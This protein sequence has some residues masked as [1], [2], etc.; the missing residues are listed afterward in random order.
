[1]TS[2]TGDDRLDE[3]AEEFVNRLRS[4]ERPALTEYTHRHPELS[5]QILELFPLLV[6]MEQVR[7]TSTANPLRV[8]SDTPAFEQ[9]VKSRPSLAMFPRQVGDYRLLREIGRGGMGI[10]YE[11]EQASL[12]RHVAVKVLLP[13]SVRDPR[14]VQRFQREARAAARLHHTNIVPVFGI[15]EHEGMSYYVMQFIHGQGLD[16]VL[17]ELRRLRDNASVSTAKPLP[18][19]ASDSFSVE[20]VTE[21]FVRGEV[22]AQPREPKSSMT[23]E[24][25]DVV[26]H[27]VRPPLSDSSEISGP[28]SG[29]SATSLRQTGSPYWQS[30]ARIGVQVAEAL[31]YAVKQGVQ[32]RD[33]KPSNLLL[34]TRGTVWVAD[35]GL[36]KATDNADLTET[37]DIIGTLRYMAPERL[38]GDSDARGDLYSLGITLYELLTLRPAFR[39]T[40]RVRL[41]HLV[42]N[43]DPPPPRA[44]DPHI[45]SDLETVVLKATTKS[46]ADRYQ[47]AAEMAADLRRFLEDKPIQARRAGWAERTWRWCRR[48]PRVAA[49]LGS[50]A[51]LLVVIAVGSTLAATSLQRERDTARNAEKASRIAE[52]I[53]V[54]AE[55]EA[56]A[57]ERQTAQAERER[58]QE[59]YRAYLAE[60][61]AAHASNQ[62]GHR[63]RGLQAVQSILSALPFDELTPAQQ[64]ELRDETIA[65]LTHADLRELTRIP[66]SSDPGHP[67]DLDP[68]FQFLALPSGD[69]DTLV[70]SIT[71]AMPDIRLTQGS[72]GPTHSL[73]RWFSPN[74]RWLAERVDFGPG[75][76]R[77]RIRFWEW[78]TQRLTLEL[79]VSRATHRPNFH[80]DG[81][82]C[83]ILTGDAKIE[84]YDL[85]S[86]RLERESPPLFRGIGLALRPDMREIVILRRDRSSEII[87]W[88]T[89]QIKSAQ[90]E[91]GVVESA[92]WKPATTALHLGT[93]DGRVFE[94]DEA[95][96]RG[97]LTPHA[98]ASPVL[99]L[100]FSPSGRYLASFCSDGKTRLREMDGHRELVVVPGELIRFSADEQRIAVK[101][102]RELVIY[103]LIHSPSLVTVMQPARA[104]DFSADGRWLALSGLH[105]VQ[106]YST[107]PPTL[108]ANL[109]LDECGPVG[110]HPDG[111]E[112]ITFG[113]FSHAVRWPLKV[114]G[115]PPSVA[116]GPPQG[117][118][119]RQWL[120]RLGGDDSI[121]QHSGRHSAWSADGKLL[122]YADNRNSHVFTVKG[123]EP[124]QV[125]ADLVN[126]GQVAV[127]HDG[128]WIACA[129]AIGGRSLVW[130]ASDRQPVLDLP[131]FGFVSFSPDGQWFVATSNSHI[132]LY[133]VG[134]WQLEREWPTD[135][136]NT[137]RC[138][139]V[140]FQPRGRLLAAVVSRHCV[141]LFD[142]TTGDVV[143]NLTSE[144]QADLSW[145]SFS[146]DGARLAVTRHD[147]DVNV[148]NLHSLQRELTQSG[149]PVRGLPET[150]ESVANSDVRSLNRGQQLLAPDGWWAGYHTLALFEAFQSNW[151]DAIGDLDQALQFVPLRDRK[152]RADLLTQRGQYHAKLSNLVSA[153]ADWEFALQLFAEQLTARRALVHL[154]LFGPPEL[155]NAEYAAWLLHSLVSR[156]DARPEDEL[157]L[158]VSQLRLNRHRAALEQLKRI[159]LPAEAIKEHRASWLTR[160]YLLAEVFAK[161]GQLDVAAT[162]FSEA[163]TQYAQHAGSLTAEEQRTLSEV[164]QSA[165][166]QVAPEKLMP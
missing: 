115:D 86:G 19:Q 118:A 157:N 114:G 40:D 6:T 103:E 79:D 135:I 12:G 121:P 111:R 90:T 138:G 36:A 71:G 101:T 48:N 47:T 35:F 97:R 21:S 31:D 117:V 24:I 144:T 147:L 137:F 151:A 3:L 20:A 102:D 106:L 94:W 17:E 83:V 9:P 2:D 89:W 54:S 58:R 38:H 13:H 51:T 150:S 4:G 44:V 159:E 34:D 55:K 116:I 98:Q 96:Q 113:K 80:P 161:L 145:L 41:V 78:G 158:A 62:Q 1:M 122:V 56:R 166:Q 92:A 142:G 153:R 136:V 155:R 73:Q 52:K 18:Q 14:H 43:D 124:P 39:E 28:D 119:I 50:V 59:L 130:R 140:A 104:T 141:R 148:W 133:R 100:T 68:S 146:P 32:H 66:I 88:A 112:L 120:A 49:L 70:R 46:P 45:P 76:R 74:G 95:E 82:H 108:K 7:P 134:T 37:G 160:Q 164:R 132:R 25:A 131:H 125:F 67:I 152:L 22:P 84:V 99:G 65:C 139:P 156:D 93:Q 5:E 87:D 162:H 143:A 91:L 10:V 85:L 109:G 149:I 105:G 23:A 75:D 15:G 60:V 26:P 30:V 128:S 126:A 29:G 11:A 107:N 165:K 63:L 33:I 72:F 69:H 127:T 27:E 163:E 77:A 81:Q 53:A 57:A 110:W 123:S 154:L 42:A 8:G 64:A 16:R 129:T 61:R